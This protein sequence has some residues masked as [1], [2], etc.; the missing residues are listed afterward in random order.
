MPLSVPLAVTPGC[1][2]GRPRRGRRLVHG[3]WP[4]SP[5]PQ[6]VR[7]GHDG[8]P[9]N[10]EGRAF[11][12]AVPPEHSATRTETS[13]RTEV[14]GVAFERAYK[15]GSSK[16]PAGADVVLSRD[17]DMRDGCE[18]S[19]DGMPGIDAIGAARFYDQVNNH[20]L[21]VF[22]HALLPAVINAGVQLSQIPSVGQD[23]PGADGRT[24]LRSS[25]RPALGSTA[26]ELI[27]RGMTIAPTLEIRPDVRGGGSAVDTIIAY[28]ENGTLGI[29]A[30]TMCRRR[31]GAH[32][33]I[34]PMNRCGAWTL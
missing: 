10:G 11:P 28:M 32:G 24:R 5:L 18:P 13:Q 34:R 16:R 30:G 7:L 9:A 14:F 6:P 4:A 8:I 22:G 29:D 21:R 23:F 17:G 31:S 25:G 1:P 2:F 26:S 3:G 12:F 20:Y 33:R 19:R 15:A 27:R